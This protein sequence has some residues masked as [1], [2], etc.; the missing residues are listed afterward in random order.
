MWEKL[1]R[2]RVSIRYKLVVL[3]LA[4]TLIPLAVA[5]ALARTN[6]QDA[7]LSMGRSNQEARAQNTTRVIDEYLT[8]RL[9]DMTASGNLPDIKD[10]AITPQDAAKRERARAAL[11]ALQKKDTNY[12]SVA[13]LDKNGTVIVSSL[14]AEDGINLKFR[15]YFQDAL[16]G[17]SNVSDA[18]V[19]MTSNRPAIFFAAPVRVENGVVAGVIRAQMNLGGILKRVTED[20]KTFGKGSS[21]MLVDENGFRLAIGDAARNFTNLEGGELYTSFKTVPEDV[22][23]RMIEERR[24]GAATDV[25]SFTVNPQPQLASVIAQGKQGS[26][27]IPG[28]DGATD[29]MSFATMTSKPWQY[30]VTTPR[31]IFTASADSTTELLTRVGLLTAAIATLIAFVFS[32][33]L[34]RPLVKLSR[35]ADAVSMGD[36]EKTVDVS[37][38]DEIGD[39]A[40]SFSRMVASVKFYMASFHE[41]D[42]D[43]SD[44]SHAA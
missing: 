8:S 27:D 9:A 6:T 25:N 14:A 31:S 28:K 24:F 41:Q 22:K 30:V 12:E 16:L 44:Q 18:S 7:L 38:N 32:M 13:I 29:V 34:T 40:S 39:L 33:T 42:G 43:T 3:F 1:R 2:P 20:N 10:Y 21:G 26:A 4:V 36:T 11:T 5:T 35:V 17:K 23:R 15:P 19:S 37:S